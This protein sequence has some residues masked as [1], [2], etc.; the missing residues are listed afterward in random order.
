MRSLR[1][2][3]GGV[4][5]ITQTQLFVC[6]GL[7]L[8]TLALFN[9]KVSN[10]EPLAETTK[11]PHFDK[12]MKL[13]Q[14]LSDKKLKRLLRPKSNVDKIHTDILYFNRVPKTGSENF[15]FLLEKLG[16]RNGFD[17]SRYRNPDHRAVSKA[18]QVGEVG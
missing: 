5:R 9:A 4:K 18:K 7:A 13:G 3:G 17:H 1:C 8:A 15:V 6:L 16:E 12:N 10:L 11:E 2:L 14:L